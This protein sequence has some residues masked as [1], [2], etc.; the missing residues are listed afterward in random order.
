[1]K[2]PGLPEASLLSFLSLDPWQSPQFSVYSL[3]DKIPKSISE[4]MKPMQKTSLLPGCDACSL[5]LQSC[6]PFTVCEPWEKSQTFPSDTIQIPH[7]HT[8]TH[9]MQLASLCEHEGKG[10]AMNFILA[11]L[12]YSKKKTLSADFVFQIQLLFFGFLSF[13]F[14]QSLATSLPH[15]QL[16]CFGVFFLIDPKTQEHFLYNNLLSHTENDSSLSRVVKVSVCVD[17]RLP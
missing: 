11:F 10:R 4:L 12:T 14:F 8:H 17:C 16:F 6:R 2:S 9:I 7:P 5:P 3:F 15:P 1:M 13:F